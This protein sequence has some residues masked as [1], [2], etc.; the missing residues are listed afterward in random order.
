[1]R[2]PLFGNGFPRR[3]LNDDGTVD[4]F[5][6]T[7]FTPQDKAPLAFAVTLFCWHWQQY[8]PFDTEANLPAL[9]ASLSTEG[10]AGVPLASRTAAV[11]ADLQDAQLGNIALP[12]KLLDR[13]IVRGEQK[14]TVENT[15][16]NCSIANSMQCWIYGYYEVAGEI[17]PTLP[18]RPLQPNNDLEAPFNA[19]PVSVLVTTDDTERLSDL[20]L[21]NE[22]YIDLLDINLT[23]AWGT[24]GAGNGK[25]IQAGL[26]FPNDTFLFIPVPLDSSRVSSKP[27]EYQPMISGLG[28]IEAGFKSSGTIETGAASLSAYGNFL[29]R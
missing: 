8:A 1:M 25:D 3:L 7:D 2:R 17:V 29:R 11:L 15:N 10:G 9:A 6:T 18:F 28:A 20:H 12:I 13:V 21:L 14:I 22:K 19:D 26:G 24:E 23:V 4:V 27:F 5:D 16:A